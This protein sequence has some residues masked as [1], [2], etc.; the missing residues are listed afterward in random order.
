MAWSVCLLFLFTMARAADSSADNSGL[1]AILS[2]EAFSSLSYKK[3]YFKF[4]I[5]KDMFI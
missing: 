2:L 3:T 1:S 5:V 4:I